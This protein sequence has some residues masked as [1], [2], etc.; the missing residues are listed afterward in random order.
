[1]FPFRSDASRANRGKRRNETIAVP[2]A[3]ANVIEVE[4][5]NRI[6]ETGDTYPMCSKA[7]P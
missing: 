5:I 2:T 4:N 1:M 3:T 7:S 6:F